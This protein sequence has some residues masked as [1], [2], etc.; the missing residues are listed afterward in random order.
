MSVQVESG[1]E[2]AGSRR[3]GRP[4]RHRPNLALTRE[5]ILDASLQ[6]IR[7]Q[8]LASLT[9]QKIAD[10]LDVSRSPIYTFFPTGEALRAAVLDH[11]LARQLSGK[12]PTSVSWQDKLGITTT[13]LSSFSLV[14]WRI[15]CEATFAPDEAAVRR[16]TFGG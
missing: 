9:V 6:I 2:E 14:V 11:V 5:L 12:T 16:M 8:D 10:A 13:L 7:Q 4:F 15:L 3:R 1:K